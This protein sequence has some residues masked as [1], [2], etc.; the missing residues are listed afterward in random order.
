[1]TSKEMGG[2]INR[3][4]EIRSVFRTHATDSQSEPAEPPGRNQPAGDLGI[5]TLG[6][7]PGH[8]T[9]CWKPARGI[10]ETENSDVLS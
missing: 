2:Q 7:G 5:D 9:R 1:M 10:C 3:G 6:R 4:Y 8:T